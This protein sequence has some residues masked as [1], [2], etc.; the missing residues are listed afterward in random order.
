MAQETQIGALYQPGGMGWGGRWEWDSKGRR[1]KY[2]CGWFMLSFDRK[3]QNSV[4]QISFNKKNKLKNKT[5]KKRMSL[6]HW[7]V[8]SR[9]GWIWLRITSQLSV[10]RAWGWEF[11]SVRPMGPNG[12]SADAGCPNFSW[13][14]PT[15]QSF[16]LCAWAAVDQKDGLR[17]G[18]VSLSLTTP[19]GSS[20]FA[21][22]SQGHLWE[23]RGFT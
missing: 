22:K 10:S 5:R 2:T 16:S 7:P 12:L 20:F 9:Q 18:G 21:T 3:Q 8:G 6:G 19:L 11:A 1:Y 17:Q 23:A 13:K 15:G 4:K 14:R